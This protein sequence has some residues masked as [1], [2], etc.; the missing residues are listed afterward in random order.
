MVP[1]ESGCRELTHAHSLTKE[2]SMSVDTRPRRSWIQLL[3]NSARRTERALRLE[4]LNRSGAIT[5]GA[6]SGSQLS[7]QKTGPVAIPNGDRTCC[8]KHMSFRKCHRDR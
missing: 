5:S 4:A 3:P 7:Y 2:G 8:R 6:P 1:G